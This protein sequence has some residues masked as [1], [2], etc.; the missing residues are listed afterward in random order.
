[1]WTVIR[2][3]LRHFKNSIAS[4]RCR[5]LI[6]ERI[7]FIHTKYIHTDRHT[8]RDRNKQTLIRSHPSM[9]DANRHDVNKW[10]SLRGHPFISLTMTVAF[11]H[12]HFC[13]CDATLIGSRTDKHKSTAIAFYVLRF[14]VAAN[15]KKMRERFSRLRRVH[16]VHTAPVTI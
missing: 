7:L 5:N 13:C 2:N 11:A 12:V 10:C 6:Y 15:G 1:M 16:S 3:F 4:S 9:L 8:D 14:D